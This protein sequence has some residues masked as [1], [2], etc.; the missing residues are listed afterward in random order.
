[1]IELF[2]RQRQCLRIMGH[3][4]VRDKS[5][6][7]GKWRNIVYFG[8]LML[9][10]SAQWPMI[11]YAIYYI[12]NLQLATASLMKDSAAK[13][14]LESANSTAIMVVKLYWISVCS[15][16]TYF[17]MSP[18]LKIIWSKIRKTNAAWELPMPMRFAF[19]FE[20]FP[21]YEFAYIYTGLVTLSVVM[22][23]VATD[24]LFVSFA[25][26]L[27]S[28]LKILQKSIENNTFLK[29]D[30]EL[31][32]DLK[33]YIEYHNLILSLYNELRDIYSPIVFGQFL[34][35]SLQVCVIV[36]QM[37][38][39]MDTILVLIINCTFLTSILLQLFIYCYGG[40][41]LKLE[42]LMVGISVQLSNWYNLK[43]A[44]RRMLVLLMLRSQREA[45]IKAG[46][47]EA[48]LANFMAIL[49]AAVSYITLIQS[50][51]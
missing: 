14:I 18:V 9:V 19:D 49:K 47:Y 29:S 10:M 44:H 20:T 12:D 46:F 43:P 32:K 31:H 30:E 38:T 40:E 5:V 45:I 34:M 22:Y 37:V 41:I 13:I 27:V 8:V 21:G 28:H 16:G 50:I 48:S 7:L 35:T 2:G 51:E 15:T 4:F 42:S 11:N 36:Y 25:I 17:M 26:N 23:A 24:G 6:L 39:H 33:S 1:M 3:Q